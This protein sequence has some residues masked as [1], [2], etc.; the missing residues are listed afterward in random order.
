MVA[1]SILGMAVEHQGNILRT[2]FPKLVRKDY[3]VTTS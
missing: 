1:D 3:G 2:Y